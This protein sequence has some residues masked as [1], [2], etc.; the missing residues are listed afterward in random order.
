MP[1]EG[2]SIVSK[3]AKT[4]ASFPV[5]P[6]TSADIGWNLNHSL[7]SKRDLPAKQ[8]HHRN[9]AVSKG[10]SVPIPIYVNLEDA[11]LRPSSRLKEKNE[12]LQAKSTTTKTASKVLG[13]FTLLCFVG[14]SV[15]STSSSCFSQATDTSHRINSHFDGTLNVCSTFALVSM[16]Q[17]ND[18]YTFKEILKQEDKNKYIEV[19]VKEVKDHEERQ[20]WDLIWHCD[21]PSNKNTILSVWSF[22]RKRTPDGTVEKWKARLCC[23]GGIQKWGVNYWEN[24]LQ[25]LVAL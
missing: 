11:G 15:H 21:M 12:K 17:N 3:G 1:S 13:F 19:M 2:D 22:K 4:S 23:R 10:A 5:T 8:P 6:S 24:M 9:S 16:H 14:I 18:V 25:L 7:T 20:H